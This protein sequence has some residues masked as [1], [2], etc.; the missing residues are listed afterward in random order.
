MQEITP[1]QLD[2]IK[3][4]QLRTLLKRVV[5]NR[6]WKKFRP[7]RDLFSGPIFN[8]SFQQCSQLRGSHNF[9]YSPQC[10]YMNFK[11]FI[12]YLDG[13]FGPHTL[14]SSQLAFQLS[15]QSAAPVS[16]RSWV[17]I[18]YGPEFF[19]GPIFNY[20][21]QQCSQ[22]RGSLNFIYSPQCKYMNFIYRKSSFNLM[23]STVTLHLLMDSSPQHCDRQNYKLIREF[24]FSLAKI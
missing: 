23:S 16:Q 1:T 6:T 12:H 3:P 20:S 19:S 11:I 5:E 7:L 22:L 9:I 14:T 21:F 10:K 2:E 18:P 17:Q 15:W 4:S 13:L 24:K 8:C